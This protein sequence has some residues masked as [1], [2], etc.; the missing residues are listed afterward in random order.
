M[1]L[2]ERHRLLH[3][4]PGLRAGV[5]HVRAAE[6]DVGPAGRCNVYLFCDPDVIF[7]SVDALRELSATIVAAD[8]GLAGEWRGDR[9][10]PDIQASFLAVRSDAYAHPD[11]VPP[12]HHGSPTRW[13]QRSIARTGDFAVAPFASNHGGFV[14]HRGRSAGRRTV[15]H[16][17][18]LTDGASVWAA[19]EARL[20]PLLEADREAEL[21]DLLVERFTAL[22][23]GLDGPATGDP[24][25]PLP[26][27]G[28]FGMD[29]PLEW[30]PCVLQRH[31]FDTVLVL[32]PPG[33]PLRLSGLASLLWPMFEHPAA[34]ADVA[35]AVIDA[36]GVDPETARHDVAGFAHS[37]VAHGALERA[38]RVP[39]SCGSRSLTCGLI[40]LRWH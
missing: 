23:T 14:L 40:R 26:E 36:F 34:P 4:G 13:M 29:E 39:T 32:R 15:P 33:E 12:V 2:V 9:D 11:I 6:Y 28:A 18:G 35:A 30:S 20:G 22:G 25:R 10:D 27:P 3:H 19:V 5:S 21:L 7:R 24:T 1:E 38:E 8:A 37:L 16:Y 31:S 17:M